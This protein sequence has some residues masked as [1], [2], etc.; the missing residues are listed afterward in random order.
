LDL[1]VAAAVVASIAMVMVLSAL[2]EEVALRDQR[3][4][5]DRRRAEMP[6]E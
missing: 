3:R 5:R 1:F 4:R 6:A 2:F